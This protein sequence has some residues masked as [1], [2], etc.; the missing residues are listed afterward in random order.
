[1]I[2]ENYTF[3]ES[4]KS[5]HALR[6]ATSDSLS[7]PAKLLKYEEREKNEIEIKMKMLRVIL[8][9]SCD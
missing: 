6:P 3:D 8:L 4:N 5:N 1:M 9:G 2:K 7:T